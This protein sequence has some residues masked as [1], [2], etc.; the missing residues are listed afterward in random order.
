MLLLLTGGELPSIPLLRIGGEQ[1]SRP[2]TGDLLVRFPWPTIINKHVLARKKGDNGLFIK[3]VPKVLY[4][5]LKTLG[6]SNEFLLVISLSW[7]LN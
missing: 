4:V 5:G 1:L 7:G 3:L 6:T 2:D